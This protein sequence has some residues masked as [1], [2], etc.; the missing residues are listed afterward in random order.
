MPNIWL[1]SDKLLVWLKQGLNLWVRIP[2]WFLD[3]YRYTYIYIYIICIS[4]SYIGNCFPF[5]RGTGCSSGGRALCCNGLDP[6][7]WRIDLAWWMHLQFGLFSVPTSDPH[8]VHQ[9]LWYVC[10]KVHTQDFLLEKLLFVVWWGFTSWQHL[11]SYLDAHQLVSDYVH[12][13]WLYS[14][15]V[16]NGEL[17]HWHHGL[18]SHS[19]TLSG[20][21]VNQSLP[22]RI[23]AKCQ[24]K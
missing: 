22:Y 20:Y 18:I 4:I 3:I 2:L 14:A 23:N 12:S 24:A 10:G 21:W 16:S 9:R 7:A 13:W 19:V 15:D 5:N 17:G 1:G 8:L 6:P 11:R